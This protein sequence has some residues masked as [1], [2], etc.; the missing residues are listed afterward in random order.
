[1]DRS[2]EIGYRRVFVVCFAGVV[3]FDGLEFGDVLR[4]NQRGL[5]A[6]AAGGLEELAFVA[7]GGLGANR[8]AV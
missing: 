4:A 5:V 2:Y 6:E 8:E 1:M 7:A 3:G